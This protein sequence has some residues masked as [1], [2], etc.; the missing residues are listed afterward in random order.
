MYILEI[1][2]RNSLIHS[3]IIGTHM[4][5]VY[6]IINTC[7]FYFVIECVYLLLAHNA[8]VKIKNSLGWTPLAEAVSYGDRQTS[9]IKTF[10]KK[11][12]LFIYLFYTFWS[13][14]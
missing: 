4:F 8:P 12:K 13:F 5:K 14:L 10:I 9:K 7:L 1:I 11:I 6:I 2:K 3:K